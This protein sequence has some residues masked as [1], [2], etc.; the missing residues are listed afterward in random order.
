MIF[1]LRTS[2]EKTAIGL[3]MILLFILVSADPELS[4]F[5][6]ICDN[7]LQALDSLIEL[8]LCQLKCLGKASL[9]GL[10]LDIN[11]VLLSVSLV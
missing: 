11:V 3:C 9:G 10:K 2:L 1:E 5:L 4:C 6:L 8:R 7:F